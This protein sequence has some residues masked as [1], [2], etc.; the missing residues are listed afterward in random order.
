M[1][2]YFLN[3]RMPSQSSL[4]APTTHSTLWWLRLWWFWYFSYSRDD[5]HEQEWRTD[6]IS[7]HD[8]LSKGSSVLLSQV[9]LL[10]LPIKII[11]TFTFF[12]YKSA[13]TPIM[14]IDGLTVDHHVVVSYAN[15]GKWPGLWLLKTPWLINAIKCR[16]FILHQLM[17]I[18][19]VYF[20][21]AST[22]CAG[23]L[24]PVILSNT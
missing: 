12:P 7:Q 15:M 11:T 16:H 6:C 18:Y 1:P 3:S 5:S 14:I 24:I 8:I 17:Y 10:F 2:C 22:V 19:I 23:F 4:T 20:T 21:S 9:C 13:K